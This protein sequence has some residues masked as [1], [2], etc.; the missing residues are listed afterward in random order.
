MLRY[1]T[2]IFI[3]QSRQRKFLDT[4]EELIKSVRST[5]IFTDRLLD[6]IAAEAYA[7]APGESAL[8]ERI[9]VFR[10]C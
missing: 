8:W 10:S 4:L 1:S 2:D 7:S 6:V 9:S 3:R 5:P